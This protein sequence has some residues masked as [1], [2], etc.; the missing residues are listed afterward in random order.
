MRPDRRVKLFHNLAGGKR[1]IGAARHHPL[2]NAHAAGEYNRTFG[3][4]LPQRS[5]YILGVKRHNIGERDYVGGVR[6]VDNAVL[7][8]C[9]RF[10]HAVVH[11]V[12]RELACG[13]AA[14]FK[15]PYDAVAVAGVVYLDNADI[16]LRGK[17]NVAEE[18][19]R[20]GGDKVFAL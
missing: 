14:L 6:V 15:S 8:V 7:A 18:L 20:T 4:A 1:Y 10:S 17:G 9:S 11:K 13:S 2:N 12:A 5:C 16:V 3:G 19:A